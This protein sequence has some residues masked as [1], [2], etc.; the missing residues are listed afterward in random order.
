VGDV[1]VGGPLTL[2]APASTE[3]RLKAAEKE[4]EQIRTT[5]GDP[6][7]VGVSTFLRDWKYTQDQVWSDGQRQ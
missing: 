5:K 2:D 3:L 1:A 6:D 4:I 7:Q